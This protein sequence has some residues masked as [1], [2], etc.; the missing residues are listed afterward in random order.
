[1]PTPFHFVH[2]FVLG[3]IFFLLLPLSPSQMKPFVIKG[4]DIIVG[5][6]DGEHKTVIIRR[7]EETI[8][9]RE[10]EYSWFLAVTSAH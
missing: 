7:I 4:V 8:D 10:D 5:V 1:M 2:E 3:A 9:V 6:H